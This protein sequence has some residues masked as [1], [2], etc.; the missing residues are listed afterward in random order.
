MRFFPDRAAL[1]ESA[2]AVLPVDPAYRQYAQ[3]ECSDGVLMT[4]RGGNHYDRTFLE[5]FMR[6]GLDPG[7]WVSRSM[8]AAYGIVQTGPTEMSVYYHQ[9]DGQSNSHLAR[10]ALRLDGFASVRT[11][12]TGGEVISKPLVFDGDKLEVN[13]ST[14]A[15]GCCQVELQDSAG[16]AIPGFTL[17]ECPQMIGDDIQRVVTWQTGEDVSRLRGQP[18]RLR[19]V[20]RDADLYSF[21][22]TKPLKSTGDAR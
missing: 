12:Y 8:V 15:A 20:M 13:I 7:N 10:F 22:F 19:F 2:L 17:A 14:S 16:V 6:P 5:A 4:S 9:H 3:H 1:S 18:V 21:S 11:P